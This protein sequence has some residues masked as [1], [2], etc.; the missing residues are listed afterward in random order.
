MQMNKTLVLICAWIH[1]CM[2]ITE[3]QLFSYKKILT[4]LCVILINV[5]LNLFKSVYS[6]LLLLLASSHQVQKQ[7]RQY[8]NCHERKTVY[9]CLKLH[10]TTTR[11]TFQSRV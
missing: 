6:I 3:V 2:H 11:K 4:C 9:S 10:I 8:Q 1:M 7:R 5:L